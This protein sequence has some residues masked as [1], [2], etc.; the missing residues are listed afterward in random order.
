M[1]SH[2]MTG[3][4]GEGRADII[5]KDAGEDKDSVAYSGPL[6]LCQYMLTK[7]GQKRMKGITEGIAGEEDSWRAGWTQCK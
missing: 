6:P 3:E 2:S 5:Y 1:F 4:G 7:S